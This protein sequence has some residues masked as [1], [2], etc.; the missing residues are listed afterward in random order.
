MRVFLV[1]LLVVISGIAFSQQPTEKKNEDKKAVA[2]NRGGPDKSSAATP[3]LVINV[4]GNTQSVENPCKATNCDNEPEKSWWHKF[5]FD[6]IATFTGALFIATAALIFT[7]W[8]QW[9]ETRNTA[10]RQ[11]RAY[12]CIVKSGRVPN[13]QN[14]AFFTFHVQA[15]NSGQTPAYDVGS[16][17]GGKLREF[18]LIGDL[19]QPDPDFIES[20]SV[21]APDGDFFMSKTITTPLTPEESAAI[22]DRT[23]AIYIY[24]RIE[25]RD[26]FKERRYTNFRLMYHGERGDGIGLK[27]HKDGNNAD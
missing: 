17:I 10:K 16:W 24:G 26:A 19:G 8:L 7:G 12:V 15:N 2:T 25:Y 22:T 4:T 23:K 9:R 1:L 14:P 5:W 18:P 20:K 3:S 11:L 27:H 21:I 13:V 6:P